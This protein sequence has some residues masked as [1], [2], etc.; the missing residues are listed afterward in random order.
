MA[1]YKCINLDQYY[2]NCGFTKRE[3]IHK[4]NL[5][6]FKT[7]FPLEEGF[8]LF[9]DYKG[10][11]LKFNKYNDNDNIEL[12]G[13]KIFLDQYYK[14]KRIYI[15]GLSIYGDYF[16]DF[17]LYKNNQL[18][19]NIR[20]KLTGTDSKVPSFGNEM[21]LRYTSLHNAKKGKLNIS[22]T[23]WLDEID[24]EQPRIID[25]I[26]LGD[27]PCMHIFSITLEII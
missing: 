24:L 18:V 26:E 11:P 17:N 27:N 20:V 9:P 22:S 19:Q 8:E 21:L 7:S 15:V 25:S 10:V 16:D 13:Q 12:E 23:I 4:G 1:K 14:V 2:N 3:E 6:V 5:T